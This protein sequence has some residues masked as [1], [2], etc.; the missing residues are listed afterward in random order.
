M[1]IYYE[2]SDFGEEEKRLK[3]E[4]RKLR[5]EY[6][7][8]LEEKGHKKGYIDKQLELINFFSQHYLINYTGQSVLEIDGDDIYEFLGSWCVRK[9]MYHN[10]AS[11]I[12]YFRAFKKFFNFLL[13]SKKISK[14]QFD[15]LM[16]E[17]NN[18]KKYVEKYERFEDLDRDADNWVDIFESWLYDADK[19]QKEQLFRD[20][21]NFTDLELELIRALPENILDEV[22]IVKDF[23]QF[24]NYIS[25]QEGGIVLTHNLFCLKKN[26]II[27]LNSI[28]KEP[29]TLSKN[30]FQKD[31][32]LIHFFFL[33]GKR[34][35]FFKY[36]KKLNLI[37]TPLYSKYLDLS[38]QEQYYILFR[39]LWN[40]ISWYRLNS[41]SDAGRPEWIYRDRNLYPPFLSSIKVDEYIPYKEFRILFGEFYGID[42]FNPFAGSWR[43]I[44]GVFIE[45]VLPLFD[46][47][48]LITLSNRDTKTIDNIKELK[49]KISPLG[50]QFFS[51]ITKFINLEEEIT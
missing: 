23:I 26:D 15:D 4:L 3:T 19:I 35:G 25:A 42:N 50:R 47:F 10:K 30:I 12:P 39:G 2:E 33:V 36:T 16:E 43:L 44:I 49:I 38:I 9:V 11:I 45:K 46:Y 40:K 5:K 24:G 18:P 13:L 14:D 21:T 41:Y 17:C 28:M 22:P 29:E 20:L 6:K 48:G 27:Q 51:G 34:L 8:Y 1:D 32:I 7:A 31:T 37:T